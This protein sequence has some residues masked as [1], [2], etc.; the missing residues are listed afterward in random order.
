MNVKWTYHILFCDGYM[1]YLQLPSIINK[2]EIIILIL[3]SLWIYM[4][5]SL[6]YIPKTGVSDCMYR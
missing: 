3:S 6:R 1:D 4:R 5:I 2:S